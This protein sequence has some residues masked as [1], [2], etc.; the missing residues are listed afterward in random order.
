MT[1]YQLLTIAHVGAAIVFVGTVTMAT[2]RFPRVVLAGDREAA[3]ELHRVTVGYGSSALVVPVLGLALA[4]QS[5]RLGDLW[6]QVSLGLVAGAGVLLAAVVVP[7]QRRALAATEPDVT[8]LRAAG[9]ALS[10]LWVAALVL[11][12]AKPW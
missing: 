3:A 9:G 10:L 5:E 12:V 6:V 2:S 1:G 11:M 8:R 7:D 4:Q